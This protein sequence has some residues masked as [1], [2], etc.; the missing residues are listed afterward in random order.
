MVW[1]KGGRKFTKADISASW[2]PLYLRQ[3]IFSNKKITKEQV[4]F[5]RTICFATEVRAGNDNRY[6]STVVRATTC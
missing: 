4:R 6:L 5:L 1:D 3:T 2:D